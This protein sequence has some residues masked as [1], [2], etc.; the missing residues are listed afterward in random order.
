MNKYLNPIAFLAYCFLVGCTQSALTS[1]GVFS[2]PTPTSGTSSSPTATPSATPSA[3]TPTPGPGTTWYIRTD[4]GTA[5]QCTGK[6]NAAYAGGTSAQ[7]KNGSTYTVG[8]QVVD[9]NNNLEQVTVAGTSAAQWPPSWNTTTGGTS[10]DQGTLVWKNMGPM[11]AAQN[12]AVNHP[13]WLATQNKSQNAFAWIVSSGDTIQFKDVGPYYMGDALPNNLGSTWIPCVGNASGCTLPAIPN[14]VSVLGLNTGNC[15]NANHTGLTG[16]TVLSAV[17][18]AFEVLNLQ[19]SNHVTL[20]CLE[21]TQPDTCTHMGSGGGQCQAG[22]NNYGGH[23]IRF[24]YAVNQ[25]PSNATMR[26]VAVVG[27]SAQG[28]LG[29][30]INTLSSDVFTASDIYVIGNGAAGWDSDGGNCGTSCESVGTMNLSYVDVEWNG[31]SAVMPYDI[32]KPTSG[33]TFNYCFDDSTG[34]YG[35]GFAFIAAGNV[36]LNV[37]HATFKYNT[38]DG[39]DSLH[40]GDDQTTTP[41]VSIM[42]SWAEGNE[43]QTFKLGAGAVG[44]AI[45]NVSI[46]NCR[47]LKTASNFPNNPTGWN[48]GVSDVCRAAGDQWALALRDGASLTVENNT[49]LGYGTT[50]YDMECSG[51][52]CGTAGGATVVFRN[53]IS[54]G[55]PDPGN[56]NRQASGIYL[57]GG[58]VFATSGSV[59]NHNLWFNMAT[60]CP[61]LSEETNA[62]CVDPKLVSEANVNAINPN[63]TSTS[64]ATGAGVSISGITT[65]YNGLTRPNPPAIGAIEY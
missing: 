65:D 11:A 10:A 37:T 27:M 49:S 34:G 23:G 41:S 28:L 54:L 29:S 8:Q 52:H 15:H 25:G 24:E 57:G 56:S 45:N 63:L 30:H 26:D 36:S 3:P 21:V 39:F 48:T 16:P 5:L 59:I 64:P 1:V 40:L 47:L 46:S 51:S 33:N 42:D 50:M 22:V 31:C 38:Q 12:C 7:W 14:S 13:F 43:G 6:T 53:N 35:D 55:F 2:T 4:G 32:S 62:I 18:G 20:Q 17:N 9:Q 61:D 44:V 60:S 58:D 19:A